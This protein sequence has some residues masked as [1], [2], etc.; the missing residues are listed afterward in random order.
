MTKTIF[1]SRQGINIDITHRC[2]LECPRCQRWSS[3]IKYGI[4]VP[5]ED[6]LVEDFAK[7]VKHFNHINFCGQISDPAHH[8]KFIE[9]LEMCNKEKRSTS[10]H[11]ATAAK[12]ISW[13]PKAFKA[14]PNARWWL[15]LDGTPDSSPIYRVNQDGWKMYEI[16][17]IA[18]EHLNTTPIWQFIVFKYN[19]NEM[20]IAFK[21]AKEIGVDFVVVNSSRWLRG[22]DPLKPLNANLALPSKYEGAKDG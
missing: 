2:S 13:Y 21:M 1:L 8:P 16:M 4:K 7:I 11:H 20:D 12:P 10:V 22:N 18:K 14:N 6:M 9:F 19:E 15:A 5:G 17:K 3:F